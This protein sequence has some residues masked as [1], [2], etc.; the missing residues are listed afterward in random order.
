MDFFK[1]LGPGLIYAGAAIGVSHLVQSTRAGA[2]FSFELIFFVVAAN[3]FKYPLLKIA[4]L[5]SSKNAKSL[6]SGY[7]EI[8]KIYL[9]LFLGLTIL[10]MFIIQAAITMV[11]AGI[12][13][14]LFPDVS[15]VVM[16]LGTLVVAGGILVSGQYERFS[17][18]IKY[19]VILLALAVI[20]S[21]FIAMK[22]FDLKD[23]SFSFVNFDFSNST[24]LTFLAAL[25]GWMPAPLDI[26]V[27]HSIWICEKLKWKKGGSKELKES[28]LDF[29]IG[30]LATTLMALLF[31]SLGA[32]IMFPTGKTFPNSAIGFSKELIKLFSF[33]SS[34]LSKL[35]ISFACLATMIST[36]LTCLDAFSRVL[37]QGHSLLTNNTKNY[38]SRYLFLT[39]FG[40][41]VVLL[42]FLDNMKSLVDFATTI[43]FLVTP[44]IA[45][46]NIKVFNKFINDESNKDKI[47]YFCSL[48]SLWIFIVFVIFYLWI[49]FIN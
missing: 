3:F 49:R 48:I 32:M 41:G 34:Y 42:F 37:D 1:K 24:H 40:A 28:E 27:W 35:T 7:L 4:H 47:F 26:S 21:F 23:A 13:S 31:V 2:L 18:I 16:S 11:T 30:Y 38:Y 17:N 6:L 20:I 12:V 5:Y 22:S 46:L 19:V 43:S 25:I 36:S 9:I 33:N 45:W 44:L 29:N 39:I 15:I 8:G 14:I 10:T